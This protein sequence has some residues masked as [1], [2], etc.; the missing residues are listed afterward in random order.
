MT[1]DV[2]KT[3]AIAFVVLGVLAWGIFHA[4]G[5]YLFNHDVRRALVVLVCVLGFLT[6]WGLMLWQRARRTGR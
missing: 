3:R 6:F 5:A 4:V 2:W 1:P